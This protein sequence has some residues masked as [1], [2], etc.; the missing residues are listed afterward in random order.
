[1]LHRPLNVPAFAP[2][3]SALLATSFAACGVL[4]LILLAALIGCTSFGPAEVEPMGGKVVDKNDPN[5]IE[6]D[7]TCDSAPSSDETFITVTEV[8]PG[9]TE[10]SSDDAS[11]DKN[12]LATVLESTQLDLGTTGNGTPNVVG[13]RFDHVGIPAD[14][15]IIAAFIQFTAFQGSPPNA[16]ANL[17]IDAVLVPHALPFATDTDLQKLPVTNVFVPW[18][19][20]RWNAAGDATPVQKTP[21]L[22]TILQP[23]VKQKGFTTDSSVAFII[24][25]AITAPGRR[26]AKSFEGS[27]IKGTVHPQAPK[28]IIQYQVPSTLQSLVVCANPSIADADAQCKGRVQKTVDDVA[29]FCKLADTCTCGLK[30]ASTAKFSDVC[31][32]P[33]DKVDVPAGCDPGGLAQATATVN[34]ADAI[35][36]GHSPLGAV[37]YGQRSICDLNADPANPDAS[38]SAVSFFFKDGGDSATKLSSAG[39][40]VEIVGNKL[41]CKPGEPCPVGV[42]HRLDLSNIEVPAGTGHDTIAQ[43]TGVGESL[44]GREAGLTKD[45][46]GVYKGGFGTGATIHSGRGRNT[47]EKVTTAFLAPNLEGIDVNLGKWDPRAVCTLKGLMV[48]PATGKV[49]SAGPPRSCNTTADCAAGGGGDCNKL[50][51]YLTMFADLRG[52]LI[53]QPP[54]AE[55]R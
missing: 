11:R 53:N 5:T 25:G 43:L 22:K 37:L 27:V 17:E 7:C 39:G 14:S 41:K 28:L 21:D 48:G 32:Q 51:K 30:P 49:C 18:P 16:D 38:G 46:S 2:S 52:L 40:R 45:P 9:G 20:D 42:T 23:V 26:V 10:I 34:S 24:R 8:K 33:C 29:G 35:C 36:L 1:M 12:Q 15:N 47:D 50:D 44:P 6:C 54:A 55:R 31:N 4:L 19:A 13:L 3:R